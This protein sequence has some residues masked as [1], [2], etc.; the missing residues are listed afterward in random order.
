MSN[1]RRLVRVLLLA[2]V[3][4]LPGLFAAGSSFASTSE[5]KFVHV[6]ITSTKQSGSAVIDGLKGG[7]LTVGRFTVRVP[8]GAWV[9]KATVQIQV[10]DPGTLTCELGMRG[11][12][13]TFL[14]PVTLET[15]VSGAINADPARF[16]VVWLN[17]QQGIWVLVPDS[18][19]NLKLL[20]LLTPLLHFSKYGVVQGK[21]G[22]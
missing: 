20:K 15:D 21:A 9:G 3:T 4:L 22:W 7:S 2:A 11:G 12:L 1:A 10:P 5:P 8:K 18:L 19:L 13:P 14:I 17:E 16:Q 6:P